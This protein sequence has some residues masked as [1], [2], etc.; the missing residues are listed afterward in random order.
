MTA[1]PEN[2]FTVYDESG[3]M[4]QSFELDNVV[5]VYLLESDDFALEISSRGEPAFSVSHIDENGA[6]NWSLVKD[7]NR[8][9]SVLM[10]KSIY[11]W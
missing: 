9:F 5:A 11:R 3:M 4:I 10:N 1:C 8:K 6:I 7:F 2:K